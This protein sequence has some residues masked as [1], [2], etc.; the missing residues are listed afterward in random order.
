VVL[1]EA[2]DGALCGGVEG[3]GGDEGDGDDVGCVWVV[4]LVGVGDNFG[5]CV[6]DECCFDAGSVAGEDE[7]GA[8]EWAFV[9]VIQVMSRWA[10]ERV[11]LKAGLVGV[12]QAVRVARMA[13]RM[14]ARVV[15]MV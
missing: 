10:C 14:T 11:R 9:G 6:G 7:D 15:R 2:L 1:F 5:E 13:G 4:E 3:A 12:M 8:F